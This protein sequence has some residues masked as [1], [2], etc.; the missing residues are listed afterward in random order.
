ML[1]F[2]FKTETEDG[3]CFYFVWFWN[4]IILL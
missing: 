3:F 1:L 4:F 2:M